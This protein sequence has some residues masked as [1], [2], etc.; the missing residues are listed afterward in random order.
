MAPPRVDPQGRPTV[1]VSVALWAHQVVALDDLG[2]RTGQ[3]RTEIVRK[4]LAAYQPLRDVLDGVLDS[5][6]GG[7]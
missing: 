6:N 2:A 3:S 1:P 5:S 7:G 4:A